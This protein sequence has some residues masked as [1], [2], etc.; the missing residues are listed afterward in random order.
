MSSWCTGTGIRCVVEVHLL[1][2]VE[3]VA[4]PR[5]VRQQVL[6]RHGVVD[7]G[8][9]VA[10]QL[11]R[12]GVEAEHAVLDEAHHGERR[13]PLR[14]TGDADAGVVGER[15]AV[16]A[17][18]EPVRVHERL[19]A[20]P[21]D[22]DDPGE[23]VASAPPSAVVGEVAHCS[24]PSSTVARPRRNVATTR[25][26]SSMPAYGVLRLRLADSVASTTRRTAGS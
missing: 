2:L 8:Q 17:V 12:P 18:G 24:L 20:G 25:P 15:H 23:A 21:V 19:L 3:V 14:A 4:D 7:E 1:G 9:V 11:A 6:D 10:E 16:G 13:E 5:P 22:P 26:G